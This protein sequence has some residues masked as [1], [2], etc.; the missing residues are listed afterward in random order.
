MRGLR[1]GFLGYWTIFAIM[2]LK[3]K[4]P[5]KTSGWRWTPSVHMASQMNPVAINPIPKAAGVFMG[6]KVG[7]SLL[8]QYTHGLYKARNKKPPRNSDGL[9]STDTIC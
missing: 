8:S 2:K 5:A 4:A 1:P 9:V 7:S 6:V 3:K